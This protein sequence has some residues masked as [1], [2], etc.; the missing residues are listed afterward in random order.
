M[1]PTEGLSEDD[2]SR[3]D[4]EIEELQQQFDEIAIQKFN[5]NQK[6]SEYSEKL[7]SLTG[8]LDR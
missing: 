2:L 7:K 6:I 4:N 3:L 8:L 5:L 1:D